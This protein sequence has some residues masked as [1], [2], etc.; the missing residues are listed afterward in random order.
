MHI[1]STLYLPISVIEID[2]VK[3]ILIFST[4][5][6]KLLFQVKYIIKYYVYSIL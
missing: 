1:E 6:E 2:L 5:I 4:E 3:E